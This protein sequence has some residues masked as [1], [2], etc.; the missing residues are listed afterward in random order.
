MDYSLSQ[1]CDQV[2][3]ARANF[4]PIEIVGGGTKRF[5]GNPS[6]ADESPVQ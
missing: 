6:L 5:Y 4:R 1:M 3:T 2:M